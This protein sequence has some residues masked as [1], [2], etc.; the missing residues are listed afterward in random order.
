MPRLFVKYPGGAIMLSAGEQ[1]KLIRCALSFKQRGPVIM[2]RLGQ[3]FEHI[4]VLMAYRCNQ[5]TNKA[6]T[7]DALKREKNRVLWSI[8]QQIA[9]QKRSNWNWWKNLSGE[10]ESP[11]HLLLY[12]AI[13]LHIVAQFSNEVFNNLPKH[14]A[15]YI[16]YI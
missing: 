1:I 10:M 13:A 4:C 2:I 5:I 8:N 14:V 11:L 6:S 16:N 7:L 15:R 12:I 3:V 9:T